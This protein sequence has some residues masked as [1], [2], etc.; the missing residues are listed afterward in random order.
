MLEEKCLSFQ[1]VAEHDGFVETTIREGLSMKKA[2]M[3]M[4]GMVH[5]LTLAL[6]ADQVFAAEPA[7]APSP[8]EIYKDSPT[9]EDVKKL[10]PSAPRGNEAAP[11]TDNSES[12]Y[13]VQRSF[14]A[15]GR[16]WADRSASDAIAPSQP[17]A[18]ASTI[19]FNLGSATV[20]PSD[21]EKLRPYVEELQST[22]TERLLLVGHTDS[23]GS[24][25]KNYILS[26]QRAKAVQATLVKM[27]A[28]AGQIKIDGRGSDD[29]NP[30][31]TPDDARQRRVVFVGLQP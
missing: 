6:A 22:S 18:F 26:M 7:S 4:A 15:S 3:T 10:W 23:R 12:D 25:T 14:D 29:P 9:R 17:V 27:G 11:P 1:R 16:S 31:L 24:R 28:P 20:R 13:D 5:I 21:A 30:D 8:K 2:L 19:W